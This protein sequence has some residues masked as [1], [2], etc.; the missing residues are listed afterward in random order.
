MLKH[1]LRGRDMS[2]FRRYYIPGGTYFFT[3]VTADRFP[4]FQAPDAR[5]LL[6]EVIRETNLST[7]FTT[8][9]IVLMPDHLHSLW[10]LPSGD[11]NYSMRWQA[12][13]A[14]FT[15][16]WLKLG[17]TEQLITSGYRTQR[18][19]GIWQPRFLE[20]TIRDET[21]LHNHA[22]YIHYNPVKHGYA[23]RPWDWQWS[24]FR[25]YVLL[26]DY[27]ENWGTSVQSPDFGGIDETLLE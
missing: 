8:V 9:A 7:P 19:R 6:G 3:L 27:D 2:E 20:H 22:D 1:N 11:S 18:R 26:G 4:L 10:T 24:S 17:H 16:S 23:K 15:S 12:I 25:R 13:K 5:K 14:R 21:D